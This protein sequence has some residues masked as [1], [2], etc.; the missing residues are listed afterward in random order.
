MADSHVVSGLKAKQ[1]EI[2]KRI[3]DLKKQVRQAQDELRTV[4]KTLR[5]FG[6]NARTGRDHL[7]R[8][9]GVTKD[10]V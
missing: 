10:R 7:F 1:E 8:R 2:K 3:S 6:E 4:S 9:G 5:I